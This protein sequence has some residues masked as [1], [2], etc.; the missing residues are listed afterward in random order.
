MSSLS[1]FLLPVLFMVYNIFISLHPN[2]TTWTCCQQ[3]V[4]QC[5]C[6]GVWELHN[7]RISHVLLLTTVC[8]IA[9]SLAEQALLVSHKIFMLAVL[10]YSAT[11]M[12][13]RW[14]CG[15][16][17]MPQWNSAFPYN[18]FQQHFLMCYI[19]FQLL[20][21]QESRADAVKP[22]R[23]KNMQKLLQFDVF[24]FISPNSISPNFKVY[25]LGLYSYTQFEIWCLPIIKFLVQI[26]ST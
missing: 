11:C 13:L 18:R 20:I 19:W 10:L 22:A 9:S 6:S 17:E 16:A 25:A 2:S 3:V 15:R 26:T 12:P 24:R 8:T 7:T 23:R 4:Q 14:K 21:K 5:S 1:F